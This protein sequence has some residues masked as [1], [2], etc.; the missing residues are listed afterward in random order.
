MSL[1]VRGRASDRRRDILVEPQVLRMHLL[2]L[3][4]AGDRD[5][6]APV[7][8]AEPDALRLPFSGKNIFIQ[9]LHI[10]I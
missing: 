3:C 1:P 5:E 9:V 10:Y 7:L 6:A 4:A 8:L 2:P